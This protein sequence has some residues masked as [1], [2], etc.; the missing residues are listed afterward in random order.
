MIS[1][2]KI[3]ILLTIFIISP[4][5]SFADNYFI[6]ANIRNPLAY[7]KGKISR[8]FSIKS[9]NIDFALIHENS[10]G[11]ITHYSCSDN[12]YD[13][14]S[15]YVP[16]LECTTSNS[17]VLINFSVNKPVDGFY[18]LAIR[19]TPIGNYKARALIPP[20]YD[21]LIVNK[22]TGK[23]IFLSNK[24]KA[25]NITGGNIKLA[26]S[27]KFKTIASFLIKNNIIV[28]NK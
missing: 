2:Y 11:V 24:I 15:I 6:Q 7:K 17:D 3:I 25:K 26:Y 12:P 16:M 10:D 27:T 8:Y 19:V 5:K 4:I 1:I 20:D 14:N 13:K 21:I 18:R 9:L 22:L 28:T 23:S